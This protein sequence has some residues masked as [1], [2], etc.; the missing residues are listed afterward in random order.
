M[1]FETS[2]PIERTSIML[3][4]HRSTSLIVRV[5]LA[6]IVVIRHRRPN[7]T[8]LALVILFAVYAFLDAGLELAARLQQREGRTG[9]RSPAA[10]PARPGGRRDRP[11]LA[12]AYRA[13]TDA[14]GRV[15]A[16]MG[17][18]LGI[19]A[20][21]ARRDRGHPHHVHPDRPDLGRVRRRAVRPPDAAR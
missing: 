5:V 2:P 21:F 20:G 12:V 1:G 3:R 6:L 8:I 13:G 15:W 17:G 9:H 18:L 16:V 19:F 10:R 7:V 14:G 4:T 11:G